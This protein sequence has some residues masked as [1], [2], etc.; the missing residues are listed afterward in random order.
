MALWDPV[1]VTILRAGSLLL[2]DETGDIEVGGA[3]GLYVAETRLLALWALRLGGNRLRLA[4][5][6]EE[7]SR[8]IVALLLPGRRH[9]PSP[10]FVRREQRVAQRG[11]TETIA[12]ANVSTA[13]LETTLSIE[14]DVDFADQFAVRSDGRVFDTSAAQRDVEPTV[15]GFRFSYRHD[16]DERSFVATATISAAPAPIVQH[17]AAGSSQLSWT[18]SL[19]PQ[20]KREIEIRVEQDFTETSLE[21]PELGLRPPAPEADVSAER[22]ESLRRVSLDDLDALLV[23]SPSRPGESVIGAGAPWFLTLFGRDSLLTA[24]LVAHR[25]PR[26]VENVLR[27]LADAQGRTTDP[28]SL[29]Q[30]GRIVHEL[31]RSELATLGMVPYGRYFGSVDATPLFLVVLGRAAARSSG[32]TL[33]LEL[34]DAARAAVTWIRGPGGLDDDGFLRFRPDPNGL[35]N[36]GWK[37]SP[38]ATCFADGRLA[39]GAIALCEVQGYAWEG[40]TATA[41]IARDIWGDAVYGAELDRVAADLRARFLTAFWLRDEAFPALALDGRDRPVD[42]IASNAGHLLWSGILP[43][44]LAH[45]VTRRLLAPAFFSGWGVRTIATG[46]VPY[47]PLSYH[48][49]S[50]W[51][52]DTM[53]AALGMVRYGFAE[54]AR[55]LAAGVAAAGHHLG[56]R[57]PELYAGFSADELPFPVTLE[58]AGVPQAWAAAAGV[59]AADLIDGALPIGPTQ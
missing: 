55:V 36:Q 5:S 51:P 40:L 58:L 33:A 20:E 43:P 13:P 8:R 47:S 12:V 17:L 50:V 27:A 54:A 2:S 3:A 56:Q 57:L 26:L 48:E 21:E 6:H 19:R 32:R 46:Q 7:A 28:T 59:V 35:L 38:G 53:L 52:H 4:G 22:I 39:D 24:E 23:P 25:A 41:R 29:E 49:G 10:A 9:A 31:R 44:N 16:R 45:A 30:P 1:V 37:D 15:D 14:L 34:E 11:L 18:L 42:A